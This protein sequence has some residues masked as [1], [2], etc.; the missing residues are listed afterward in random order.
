MSKR[1]LALICGFVAA[2]I[3]LNAQTP[4]WIWTAISVEKEV[5]KVVELALSQKIRWTNDELGLNKSLTGLSI[6]YK[7][8]KFLSLEEEGQYLAYKKT[9]RTDKYFRL[10]SNLKLKH[11][12]DRL[13]A[14]YRLRHTYRTLLD[15]AEGSEKSRQALRHRVNVKYDLKDSHFSP[16]LANEIFYQL[17]LGKATAS[18]NRITAGIEYDLDKLGS[19]AVYYRLENGLKEDKGVSTNIIGAKYTFKL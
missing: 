6:S 1:K 4:T 16:Y 14:S 8:L 13:S 12:I 2:S 19:V 5:S 10:N 17:A 7:A 18:K 11:K 9:D 15:A 3:G